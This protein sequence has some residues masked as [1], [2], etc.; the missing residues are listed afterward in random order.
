MV[1]RSPP[2][3]RPATTSSTGRTAPPSNPRTDLDVTTNIDVTANFAIDTFTLT[4]AAGAGGS[5]T[6]EASQMVNYGADGT[7]VTAVPSIG[8]HFTG[9]SDGFDRQPPHRPN[10]TAN[11]DVTANF[12]IDTFTLTYTAGAGGS[13]AGE[14]SQTVAYLGSGTAVTAVPDTGYHF[15]NWSDG[16][17]ANSRTDTS[18]TANVNVTANFAIDTFTLNY[19][20]GTGGVLTGE[21][22]QVVNY[23]SDGSQVT[24]VPDTGYHFVSWSDGSTINPRTDENITSDLNVTAN[25]A[26]N[27]FTL[28]YAAGAGGS[29]EGIASQTVNY[30]GSG[31]AVEAVPNTGYHFVNWSDGSTT[32]PR[33]DPDVTANLNVTANFAIDTFTLNYAAGENGSLTGETS[34]TVNYGADGSQVTAV[35]S[36]GYH[37][38]G[39]V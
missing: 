21:A 28:N 29:L 30:N 13:L 24:A 14:T 1:P 18:I 19:T 16:S 38:V 3:P 8:Y 25:F 5:L 32:N 23:G 17:T 35:P 9:W 15:V 36:T 39:L 12:A 22:S 7:Q 26:I 31:T 27:T 20:S 11:V 2:S 34:Q 4:Y 10:V 6:G 33:T 37:F